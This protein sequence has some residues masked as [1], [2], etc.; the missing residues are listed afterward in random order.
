MRESRERKEA[1]REELQRSLE[2]SRSKPLVLDDSAPAAVLDELSADIDKYVAIGIPT[3]L[4]RMTIREPFRIEMYK[5]HIRD[6]CAGCIV[7]FD[8]ISPLIGDRRV[9]RAFRFITAI[10]MENDREIEL[11][12]QNGGKL[13]LIGK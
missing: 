11:S 6:V 13:L 2:G 1:S 5:Q 4:A 3:S 12:Q 10:F 7:H 9:D 8:G